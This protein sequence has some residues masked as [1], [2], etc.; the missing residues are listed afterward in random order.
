MNDKDIDTLFTYHNPAGL[1]PA[2]FDKI[3]NAAKDLGK[4]ILENGGQEVDVNTSIGKL[5]E[6]VYFAIASIVVPKLGE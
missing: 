1:D 5:R 6:C 4:C 3:R 2:R